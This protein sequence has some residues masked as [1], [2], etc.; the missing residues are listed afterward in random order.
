[1]ISKEVIV[2]INSLECLDQID[3]FRCVFITINIG[4]PDDSI[5]LFVLMLY[6]VRKKWPP[7]C[8]VDDSDEIFDSKESRK[9][10]IPN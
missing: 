9:V 7:Y 1:M 8:L 3:I 6:F 2:N 5:I 10:F 4:V